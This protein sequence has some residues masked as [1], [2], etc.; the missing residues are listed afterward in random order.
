MFL[1][2]ARSVVDEKKIED[3]NC[4]VLIQAIEQIKGIN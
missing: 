2:L 4:L 1:T 3:K